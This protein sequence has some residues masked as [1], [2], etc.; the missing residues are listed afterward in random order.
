MFSSGYLGMVA[1]LHWPLD[2][3]A[4]WSSSFCG[5]EI[6]RISIEGVLPGFVLQSSSRRVCGLHL[7]NDK[8]AVENVDWKPPSILGY[9]ESQDW[10]E[11]KP[12][13]GSL[14]NAVIMEGVTPGCVP[15][16]SFCVG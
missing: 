4:C 1:M 8:N 6:L 13:T 10:L 16:L 12:V 14:H 3:L 15:S 7:E 2:T 11:Y 9:I 5:V